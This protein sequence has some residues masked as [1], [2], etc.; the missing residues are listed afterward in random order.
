MDP[1]TL[2][3]V[4]TQATA[5][6]LSKKV[7]AVTVKPTG[8]SVNAQN[9]A[10]QANS[11]Y[12]Y[13]TMELSREY[14]GYRMKSDNSNVNS[15]TDQNNSIVD[16]KFSRIDPDEEEKR[17]QKETKSQSADSDETEDEK[18]SGNKLGGYTSSELKGLV[19]SGKITVATYNAEVKS[20]Q[21]DAQ[22]TEPVLRKTDIGQSARK[23][24]N[25]IF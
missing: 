25:S 21:D 4:G 22:P 18:V 8:D 10:N 16:Q 19:F 17:E 7:D 23:M 20:R 12:K 2:N 6:S 5:A 15:D 3:A 13:D 1:V 24:S 9:A 11:Y 14:L